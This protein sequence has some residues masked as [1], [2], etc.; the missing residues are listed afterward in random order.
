MTGSWVGR[1][2][3][4]SA[5]ATGLMRHRILCRT[6]NA[7]LRFNQSVFGGLVDRE[8]ATQQP[9]NRAPPDR[10]S[11]DLSGNRCSPNSLKTTERMFTTCSVLTRA[12]R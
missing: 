1:A 3:S 12:V 8:P 2:I 5:A 4:S 7:S 10:R 9:A 11:V 6:M